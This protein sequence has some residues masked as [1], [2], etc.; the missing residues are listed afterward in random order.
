MKTNT[1]FSALILI[2]LVIIIVFATYYYTIVERDF[3]II[4]YE[5]PDAVEP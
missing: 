1:K 4:N 5:V 3:E 2:I